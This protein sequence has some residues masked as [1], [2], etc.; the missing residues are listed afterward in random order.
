MKKGRPGTR[1]EVLSRPATAAALE[2]RLLTESSSI[3][4]R[5]SRLERRALARDRRR[6]E[7]L[8]HEVNLKVVTLPGGRR[9]TKPEFDDVQ[10]VAQAT[11]RLA[12]DIFRLAM[13]AGERL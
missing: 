13:E 7:V 6:V 8:G 1:I 3:G 4:V 11:G 2:D 9:R 5:R 10:R 12:A